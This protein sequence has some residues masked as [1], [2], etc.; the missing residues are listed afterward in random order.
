MGINVYK[1]MSNS[2]RNVLVAEKF[3]SFMLSLSL[4][5]WLSQGNSRERLAGQPCPG[6]RIQKQAGSRRKAEKAVR[7]LDLLCVFC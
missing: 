3:P 2:E 1:D 7:S 5:I 4:P 6:A